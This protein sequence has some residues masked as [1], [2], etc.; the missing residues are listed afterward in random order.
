[1]DSLS[2]LEDLILTPD[3]R[4]TDNTFSLSK[5]NDTL[6]HLSMT[7]FWNLY[8]TQQTRVGISRYDVPF[9]EFKEEL[10]ISGE[11]TKQYYPKRY[12]HFFPEAFIIPELR[13]KFRNSRFYAKS[14]NQT[15]VAEN[16]NLFMQNFMMFIDGQYIATSEVYPLE[17]K[18][19][20]I[21]DVS[22]PQSNH[23]IPYQQYRHFVET[24]KMVTI[25]FLPNFKILEIETNPFI[26]DKY[27]GIIPFDKINGDTSMLSSH[28]ICMMNSGS[29]DGDISTY[30]YESHV[31][32][33]LET[34]S[35]IFK[36]LSHHKTKDYRLIFLTIPKIIEQLS[37]TSKDPYFELHTK[38]PCPTENIFILQTQLATP[39]TAFN[40]EIS[41]RM[42]YPNIYCVDNIPDQAIAKVFILQDEE[43][44]TQNET[45]VDELDK[46]REYVDMLPK[47][48][49]NTIPE[50]IK[51]YR[52]SKFIYSI[53][54]YEKSVYVPSTI[55]YKV[56][57]LNHMIYENP[58]ALA[59]YSELL[60]LPTGKFYIDMTKIDLPSRI[61]ND[62]LSEKHDSEFTDIIFTEPHYVFAMNRHFLNV[63]SYAF[64]IFV[65]GFFQTE[66]SYTITS[67]LDYYYIYLPVAI[68]KKDTIIELER[69]RLYQLECTGMAYTDNPFIAELDLSS[70]RACGY[71]RDIYVLR[72]ST[73]EYLNP[74]QYKI[75]VLYNFVDDDSETPR[76]VEVSRER[77]IPIE[78]KVKVFLIDQDLCGE[79]LT[80]GIHRKATMVSGEKYTIPDDAGV[81]PLTKVT[82]HNMGD[83]DE[84][85]YRMFNN[86]RLMTPPQYQVYH[87]NKQGDIDVI[88]TKCKIK[89]GDR[90]TV[91]RVP[92][93]FRVVHYQAIVD[94]V[95]KKGYVDLD[96]KIPLPISLRWYDIYLNGQKLNKRH[97]EIFSPTRF[98][99]KNV[100][101]RKNLMIV[102][103][104][105]DPEVFKL[106]SHDPEFDSRDWNNSI[107]D[108]II[109]QVEDFKDIIEGNKP[110]I[111]PDNSFPDNSEGVLDNIDSVIFFDEYLRYSFINCNWKQIK[112]EFV[113]S[114]PTLFDEQHIFNID[115]ND[116]AIPSTGGQLIKLI[117]CNK[118]AENMK[119][120]PNVDYSEISKMQDRFALRPLNTTKHEYALPHEFMC[121]PV[122]AE[123]AVK[124][125]DGTVTAIS[126]TVRLRHH[127]EEFSNAITL[128]GMGMADIYHITFEDEYHAK[129]YKPETNILDVTDYELRKDDAS[130]I[131][132]L[133]ISIDATILEK[134]EGTNLLEI[135]DFDPTVTIRYQVGKSDPDI[136][137]CKLSRL[138]RQVIP[139]DGNIMVIE[140]IV[141]TELPVTA[142]TFIHSVLIAF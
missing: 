93:Q 27:N 136:M 59:I 115:C 117:E 16:D 77:N 17:D 72:Q 71:T 118:G 104:D 127:I 119:N 107:I 12:V 134:H 101:S 44:V 43:N 88:R 81:F 58:W 34:K 105:R 60:N 108:D 69:Y 48:K 19:G 26:V 74:S 18:T 56:N 103:R 28:T 67:N 128:Y 15:Q 109:D 78:N 124:N 46:Y 132:K 22:T 57:K 133:C 83:Y 87:T 94:E 23:G 111:D 114:F 68:I 5:L 36:N 138:P 99:I 86:G 131:K 4:Y 30:R 116:G 50:I 96:G 37:I 21:I 140:S 120:D 24:N 39:E 121:D 123:T 91:D 142:T 11:S 47:Y 125:E 9:N 31:T 97:I 35:L 32:I 6:E 63:D 40:H 53:D 79:L 106:P 41:I 66:D 92:A 73:L 112:D 126:M 3:Q 122:T 62:T 25:F 42:Y 13:S 61:R 80:V 1:M 135:A 75:K 90:F 20:I 33:D 2:E 29:I 129:L 139:V 54:D 137:S 64:R 7:N 141:L 52:P 130:N 100:E 85:S 82:I 84:S 14:I 8:R 76:Y 89:S 10:R 55:N 49:T 65:D 51:Q 102:V 95:N 113:E 110:Q 38:M 70:V 98:Y 45:Y